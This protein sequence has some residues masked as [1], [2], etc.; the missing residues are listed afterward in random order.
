MSDGFRKQQ[1]V[2]MCDRA[3]IAIAGLSRAF[4]TGQ[5]RTSVLQDISL[6]IEQGSYTVIRGPSGAGKT[7]LLR[8]L[9]LLDKGFD[10][11]F[12]YNGV[13]VGAIGSAHRDQLR[14]QGVGFIFQEGRFLNHLTMG[15][16]IALPLKLRG[17]DPETFTEQLDQVSRFVFRDT[18]LSNGLMSVMPSQASGGQRQRAAVARAIITT[19]DLILADEPTA[20]LDPA[21]RQQVVD[22]LQELHKRGTTVIVVSHDPIFFDYGRQLELAGGRLRSIHETD[23]NPDAV[24][25]QSVVP[26]RLPFAP[27]PSFLASWNVKLQPRQ[28]LRE[29]RINLIRRPLLS[30]LAL[31]SLI[32]GICQVAIFASLIGGVDRVIENAVSDGSRLTR[33]LIRPRTVDL[34][35]DDRFPYVR[36][37]EALLEVSETTPRRSTSFALLDQDGAQRP[38]QTIGLHP[39]DPELRFFEFLAGAPPALGEDDF[40]IIATP[41]FLTDIFGLEDTVGNGQIDW[42]TMIGRSVDVAIPRFNSAGERIGEEQIRLNIAAVIL[43]GEGAREFYVANTLLVATDAIKRDRTGTLAL[44]MNADRTGWSGDADIA[45]L[46][47]WPWEDMLHVYATDIDSVL[48]SLTALVGFGYRP[49]AEIWSYLWVLDLKQAA[50]RIFIP[51]LALLGLVISLVLVSNIYISARLREGE[52]AL[53]RVLGMGRGDLLAIE[54]LGIMLLSSLAAILGLGG[55]QLLVALLSAQF[56]AQANMLAGIPDS[57]TSR[58]S[59]AIFSPVITFAPQIFLATIVLVTLAALWPS[60]SVARTDPAKVFSRP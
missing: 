57:G 8:I 42:Q 37:I 41:G 16:N 21:S 27:P 2:A 58:V 46:T 25:M 18:E 40:G 10:G 29:A 14:S 3:L 47:D 59:G 45:A 54:L 43:Q 50:M 26:A 38:Y 36:E 24:D 20:S 31:V 28:L 4:G 30:A 17:R 44:P 1:N 19:P 13:D 48:P 49:E 35:A 23:R 15:E 33:T 9:G 56:E 32:A 6:Q 39:N 22:K 60:L 7:T 52:L 5:A 12:H 34:Q 51:V 55:A 53:C 11:Q